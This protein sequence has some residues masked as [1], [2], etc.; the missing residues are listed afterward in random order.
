MPETQNEPQI[1]APGLEPSLWVERHGSVMF[2]Y[3]RL[4]LPSAD[5]A[6]EAVQEALVA[7]WRSRDSFAGRS[8]E[9]TWLI[10]ILRYKILDALRDRSR[11]F[12]SLYEDGDTGSD[13]YESTGSGIAPAC[14]GGGDWWSDPD[15]SSLRRMLR[16]GLEDLPEPMRTALVLREID[17][18]PGKTVCE[19]LGVT[20]TNLWTMIHRA[21][22]RLR[23][24]ISEKYGEPESEQG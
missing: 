3:A 18:I 2:G 17:G 23:R 19:I 22:S 20:E 10:G 11:R 14:A 21:K 13:P 6:E 24:S 12:G 8:S 7:A 16:E 1:E 5:M 15:A 9:R 4:R